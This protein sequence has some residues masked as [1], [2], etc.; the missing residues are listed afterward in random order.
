MFKKTIANGFFERFL[1]VF[2]PEV[3]I[4]KLTADELQP[5][6]TKSYN[7]IFTKLLKRRMVN[8]QSKV[9]KLSPEAFTAVLDWTNEKTEIA[10]AEPDKFRKGLYAK[11]KIY[12]LRFA[13]ILELLYVDCGEAPGDTVGLRAVNGAKQLVDFFEHNIVRAVQACS[14]DPVEALPEKQQQVYRHLKDEFQT[15]EAIAL[16]KRF[17]VSER[18]V[19]YL[20]TRKDLFKQIKTGFYKKVF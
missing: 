14:P 3:T 17:D 6:V 4:S 10:N 13:L 20:L 1:Y 7:E 11:Q 5:W 15:W 9:L 19:K 8:R 18:T 12:L 2:P 16:G